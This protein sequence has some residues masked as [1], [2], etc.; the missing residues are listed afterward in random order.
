MGMMTDTIQLM[1]T[2]GAS[3]TTYV[4]SLSN[5]TSGHETNSQT[6]NLDITNT[7]HSLIIEGMGTSPNQ[8]VIQQTVA[9]PGFRNCQR[10]QRDLREL[11][12]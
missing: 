7:K 6:G 4:L 10:G 12:N 11:G 2:S 8:T 3:V 9:R 1:D 5:G